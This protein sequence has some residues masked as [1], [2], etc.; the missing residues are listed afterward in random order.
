MSGRKRRPL[1][2]ILDDI[3]GGVVEN[4]VLIFCIIL[5]VAVCAVE[6]IHRWFVPWDDKR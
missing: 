6:M 3:F 1:V 2:D 4:M 5:A